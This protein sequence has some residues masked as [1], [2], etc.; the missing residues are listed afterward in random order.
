MENKT[1]LKSMRDNINSR[2]IFIRNTALATA[3]LALSKYSFAQPFDDYTYASIAEISKLIRQKK[4]SPVEITKACL[5]RI[6]LLNPKLNAFITVTAE[7]ALKEAKIAETEIKNGKWK[8]PLHGIPVALKDNIDTAGIRTTAASAVFK[9]RIPTEDAVLVKQL[10]KAGAIIIGKTNLHEFALGTTSHISYYGAVR[11]PWNKEFIPGGSSGGSGVAVAA[12]MCYAAM[13][14][15]T[16]GSI[17][18]P[19]SCCG[20]TGFK[21]TYGLISTRGIIPVIQS[22]DH[23]GPICRTVEDA[24][25]LLNA[26]ASPTPEQNNCK[27]NYQTSINKIKNPRIGVIR[28]YKASD[29]VRSVFMKAVSIFQSLG[30]KTSDTELPVLPPSVIGDA[31]IEAYHRHLMDRYKE[32]YDPVTFNDINL[33]KKISIT[34]YINDLNKMEEDRAAISEQLFKNIDVYILPT[35]TSVTPTIEEAKLKGPFALE[36]FNTEF[37]Y[38]GLPAISI[39]CGFDSNGM[40]LGL[41]IVGPRWG[42][43]K[44]LDIALRYQQATRWH[45]K[46]PI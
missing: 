6:E 38:Y 39:P 35:T 15:D 5:R 16:G 32:L 14:T 1:Y 24:A 18:L 17:R 44:V 11:N 2:R 8:G 27:W 9:D 28:N 42:E 45:L 37:N 34:D 19:A 30:F 41:H 46:H 31:E 10:K 23:A 26:L 13:A 3:G 25:I 20:V 43:N 29:E 21:P 22:I 36:P 33:S 40:P 12:G 4:V 7:Q